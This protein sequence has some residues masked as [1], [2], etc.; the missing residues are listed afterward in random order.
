M[1]IEE[2]ISHLDE[3]AGDHNVIIATKERIKCEFQAAVDESLESYRQ[4]EVGGS[5]AG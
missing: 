2:R 4:G 5:D 3:Y 1:T